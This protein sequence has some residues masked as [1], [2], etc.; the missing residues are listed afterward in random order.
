MMTRVSFTALALASA[1]IGLAALTTPGISVAQLT[2]IFQQSV[3]GSVVMTGN[4]MGRSGD[5]E[6]STLYDRPGPFGSAMTWISDTLPATQDNAD[7]GDYTTDDWTSNHSYGELDLAAIGG[8]E[9]QAVFLMWA[10]SCYRTNQGGG[11]ENISGDIDTPVTFEYPT[12]GSPVQVEVDPDL[13]G[14]IVNQCGTTG[15]LDG[16]VA[17]AEVTDLVPD[18]I[19]GMYAVGGVPGTQ[20][21]DPNGGTGYAGWVMSVVFSNSAI[22]ASSHQVTIWS[23]WRRESNSYNGPTTV[24]GFCYPDLGGDPLPGRL[25]VAAVEGDAEITGD[26][27]AFGNGTP[28]GNADRVEGPRHPLTNFFAAQIT[29]RGGEHIPGGVNWT[30][31][32]HEPGVAA[33]GGRQGL[34]VADVPLNDDTGTDCAG[35]PCN[36]GVLVEN[37]T[38]A[39]LL[40]YSTGDAY[41]VIAL[42]LDLPTESATFEMLATTSYAPDLV[43]AD[44]AM[45]ETATVTFTIAI[46]NVGETTATNVRLHHPLPVNVTSLDSITYS[47]DGGPDTVPGGPIT[48]AQLT[49]GGIAMP[50]VPVTSTLSATYA[51]AVGDHLP[52]NPIST[53]AYYEYSWLLCG[54]PNSASVESETMTIDIEH[55]G[56]DTLNG[57]PGVELCDGADVGALTCSDF[58]PGYGG[59]VPG[60]D[61]ACAALTV[62]TC[63]EDDDGDDVCNDD[64]LC[65]GDDATGDADGDGLCGD[66]E[67]AIGTDPDDADSD[68]DGVPDGDEPNYADDTDGDGLINALD[69]DS[70][71]DGLY[72]GTEMGLTLEDIGP[73]TDVGA[74]HFVPDADGGATTTDPLEADTDGG[75]VT[76][77]A[78]DL[79]LNGAIDEGETDPTAGH[80]A[81]DVMVDTDGDGLPD[82]Q[83]ELF[84]TDPEDADS[85]NDGVP[86]GAEPNW[87]DDTDGDGLIN[88]LDPDSDNDGLLDGTEM[89]L[90]LDDIGPDTDLGAG[91]FVPD[92]DGGATTTSPVDPDTD[93]GGVPDGQEDWDHDGM[94]DEG[95]TDPND[96]DDDVPFVDTDDDG[97]PDGEDN[98]PDIYNPDQADSDSDGV[99][100][101][102][103]ED[104]DGGPDADTDA[105]TDAD[106]DADTDGDSDADTDSDT[107]AAGVAAYGATGSGAL[108]SCAAGDLGAA[109][110]NG[111][112][113]K[114]AAVLR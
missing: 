90:T 46:E 92:A 84:G 4:T 26:S 112:L 8:G 61:P 34:D 10:G 78:E 74:G 29:D 77:G 109:G 72:D 64:D 89:G 65:I 60:C 111:L 11:S 113:G 3:R 32:D 80:G 63:C 67:D 75:G 114:L 53:T 39:Y 42:A 45:G 40:P 83:E 35:G 38:T 87:A 50:D 52:D 86:D 59:G 62:G 94:I 1:A 91:N 106:S 93:G 104:P 100:D 55:C 9:I 57:L 21:L 7:W 36:P 95:E 17:W 43:Y 70:D 22:Y 23:G 101:A 6:G 98:C 82:A 99:G 19:D 110:G 51:V 88:A 13:L 2:Q 14:G 54:V 48:L 96:P 97:V 69:P 66:T 16:Y 79:N 24:S 30:Q 73:D 5:S 49:G 68:N 12:S 37:D 47:L 58:D 41:S 71:N 31:I 33:D 18:W 25:L 107:D 27:F 85:D 102:C 15:G 56:D 103:E 44:A 20:T 105:D 28:L 81:D 108:W 76:D